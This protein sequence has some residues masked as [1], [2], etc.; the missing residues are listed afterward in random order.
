MCSRCVWWGIY[1]VI[2]C[3]MRLGGIGGEGGI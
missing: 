1:V 2:V 3:T